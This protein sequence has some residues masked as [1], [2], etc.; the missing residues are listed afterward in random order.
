MSDS[1][2]I[3]K[4]RDAERESFQHACGPLKKNSQTFTFFPVIDTS[5]MYYL[6]HIG[7]STDLHK[8]VN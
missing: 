4:R 3:S 6:Y 8:H 7:D 2:Q 1:T 5:K